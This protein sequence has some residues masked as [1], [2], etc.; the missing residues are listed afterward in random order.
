MIE[1]NH[2]LFNICER[3]KTINPEYR[4]VYNNQ[5][6]RF[7]VYTRKILAFVVPFEELDARVIEYAMKT[8]IQNL[9]D[10]F[11]EMDARNTATNTAA[12]INIENNIEEMRKR[13]EFANRTG[14][15]VNFTN[16]YVEF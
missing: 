6:E 13:L 11:D 8:R 7:E 15:T 3:I 9:D 16:N 5:Y 10:M 1:I 2:D 12:E 4:I 14:R